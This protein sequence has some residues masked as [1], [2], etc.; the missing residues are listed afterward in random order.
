MNHDN[1]RRVGLGIVV[2]V[3]ALVSVT[4]FDDLAGELARR[5]SF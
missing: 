4:L 3:G 2:L 5:S 1:V